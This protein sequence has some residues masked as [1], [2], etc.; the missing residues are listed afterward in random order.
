M[1]QRVA[2]DL[3]RPQRDP[4]LIHDLEI[5]PLG[6]EFHPGRVAQLQ[7]TAQGAAQELRVGHLELHGGREGRGEGREGEEKRGVGR[8]SFCV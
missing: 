8:M 3:Q 6:V 2:S 1:A 5:N 7:K 4:G